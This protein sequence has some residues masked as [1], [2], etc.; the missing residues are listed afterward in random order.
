MLMSFIWQ[1]GKNSTELNNEPHNYCTALKL[2]DSLCIKSS[3]LRWPVLLFQLCL[4]ISV[5]IK[6]IWIRYCSTL[7]VFAC[8]SLTISTSAIYLLYLLNIKYCACLLLRLSYLSNVN[9]NRISWWRTIQS[10]LYYFI[11]FYCWLTTILQ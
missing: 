2:I 7:F 9:G 11:S 1:R 4:A 3:S 10:T 6:S 8:N 5:L